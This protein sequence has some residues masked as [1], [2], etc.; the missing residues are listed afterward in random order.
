[1]NY[2]FRP[3]ISPVWAAVCAVLFAVTVPTVLC[4]ETAM[5]RAETRYLL[6]QVFTYSVATN[7][8]G[9]A[10]F[11]PQA[12]I[13]A[14][15]DDII[16]RIGTTGDVRSKLGFAVG[17]LTLSHGDEETRKLIRESFRIAREKNVAVAFHLDD[18]MFWEKNA[19]LLQHK[20]EI[21]EWLDWKRSP[22][23]GRRLDWGP[24]P[25]KI[26]PQLCLNSPVLQAVV[27]RRASFL[28]GEIGREVAALK[29]AG[30]GELFAGV[31]AGWETQIGRDFDTNRCCGF[32]ALTNRGLTS[33][34]T[35]SQCDG[36]LIRIVQEF[37]ALWSRQLVEAGIPAD[38]IYSHIAFT[39]QGFESAGLRYEEQVGYATPEVAFGM[40]YRPGFST[41]PFENV[42]EQIRAEASR[43]GKTWISAEGT[44]V[45][46]NG[47]PGEPT[48]ETYLGKM[49]NHGAVM[50]NIF[51]W[52]IGGEAM[53][54]NFFRQA[55]ENG[56]AI[57]AYRKFLST[58]P[59]IESKRPTTTFSPVAFQR[60][61]RTIQSEA[62]AWIQRTRR[63]EE[64]QP[65]MMRLDSAVKGN[66]F[67]EADKLADQIL[68]LLKKP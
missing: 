36:A 15:V 18:Q 22:C 8:Q 30:K 52:G 58:S 23:T 5:A 67:Q 2:Q 31:I 40:S 61:V 20:N 48:M 66:Q 29:Q 51:S 64:I 16:R 11:P 47:M 19:E 60:K 1:M 44:N 6:F 49:F 27:C 42:L 39:P 34:N 33:K 43:R 24:K 59:L 41:Y 14:T 26:S 9:H 13:A 53:R 65:L 38:K 54:S 21:I 57:S 10:V 50:V 63:V 4:N 25:D 68:E 28:G 62:P 37:I 35:H 56:E 45:V 12:E 46:P 17:P 32:R 55:T 3:V 7:S